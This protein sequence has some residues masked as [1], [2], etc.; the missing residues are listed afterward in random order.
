MKRQNGHILCGLDIGTTKICALI[1][2]EDLISNQIRIVG[3][4][5]YPSM[6]LRKGVVVDLEKTTESIEGAIQAAE[7]MAGFTVES[8]FVGIAGDHIRSLNSYGTIGIS[9]S[10]NR[11]PPPD[12]EITHSDVDAVLDQARNI[13][14]SMDR[15]IIHI[16]PQEYVVD[17]QCGIK[18]PIGMSGR[19]LEVR[20]HIVTGT[21]TSA[22]NIIK[23]VK[24]AG[25][26][27]KELVLEPL[28]SSFAVLSEDEKE[29]GV[30]LVDIGGGTTD[31][32]VFYQGGV[33]H[34][35]V[36]GVGGHHVTGDIAHMLRISRE[37]AEKIK[38]E[39]GFAS[40]T[41]IEQDKTIAVPPIAGRAEHLVSCSQLATYIEPRMEEILSLALNEMKKSEHF[42]HLLVGVVLTGGGSLLKGTELLAESVFGL[43]VRTGVPYGV[44]GNREIL[45]SPIYSTAVGLLLYGQQRRGLTSHFPVKSNGHWFR[46]IKWIKNKVYEY[47]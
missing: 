42:R 1:A 47:V 36:L 33:R 19:R 14:L 24:N 34:T 37:T 10:V 2:E 3:Y 45:E 27:V 39:H 41:A 46:W 16:L 31:V 23:S 22:K 28:A 29:Q 7:K 13:T 9:H 32:T 25:I 5:I 15:E 6:G 21:I 12:S 43:P 44:V 30:A 35:S 38:K 11:Q 17:G 4:G 8:A 40:L 18:D 20:V 26:R